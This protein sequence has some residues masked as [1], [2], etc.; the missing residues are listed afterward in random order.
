M[1][2]PEV[3]DRDDTEQVSPGRLFAVPRRRNLLVVVC[4]GAVL[5][6]GGVIGSRRDSRT[7]GPAHET[8]GPRS[9]GPFFDRAGSAPRGG[10]PGSL[11]EVRR[12]APLSSTT[13]AWHILYRSTDPAGRP[14]L[15]SGVVI[16]PDRDA[17]P[18]GFPLVDW[19]HSTVGIADVC[20]PSI[21]G[22]PPGLELDPV[23]AAGYAIVA[24]DYPGLGTPGMP[25]YLDG[26]SEGRAM[27]D[28]ARAA[29]SVTELDATGPVALWGYSQGGQAVLWAGQLAPTYAPELNIIGVVASAALAT[30]SWFDESLYSHVR[31]QFALMAAIAWSVEDPTLDLSQVIG[32][33]G[34]AAVP[35]AEGKLG[36]TC[37]ETSTIAEGRTTAELVTARFSDVPAWRDVL[38]RKALP[39][40]PIAA[41]VMLQQGAAD[42][43]VPAT[44]AF[45]IA[46]QLCASGTN[47]TFHLIDQGSHFDAISSVAPILWLRDRLAGTP[48][49]DQCP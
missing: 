25:P 12:A 27:L 46:R 7:V 6:G 31:Y 36:P 41:P 2:G 34:L 33:A 26:E 47:V 20:T 5:I 3:R 19:G 28:A 29:R 21:S 10:P 1:V 43:I 22:T 37:P 32:P 45:A 42:T 16:R 48:A 49:V 8:G 44:E 30:A 38:A 24:T 17:P 40:Q 18:G 15:V 23:I 9:S 11:V 39:A 35:L 4:A 13:R 14:I